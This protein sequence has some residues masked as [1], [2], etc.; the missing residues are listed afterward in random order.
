MNR[1]K[2]GALAIV[3][4]ATIVALV[5][6]FFRPVAVEVAY[7]VERAKLMLSRSVFSRVAG[8]FRG[9]QAKAENVRLRRE[10]ASL[11]MVMGECER[12]EEENARLRAALGYV[13]R[14]PGRWLA[15][16][17]LSE[18]GAAAGVGRSIRVDRG[19]LAGVKAGAVVA[20]PE[21]LVG[22]VV[23]VSPHTAEIRLITDSRLKVSCS[24]EG[25]QGAAGVLSGGTDSLLVLGLLTVGAEVPPRSRVFTSGRGGVFPAGIEVGTLLDVSEQPSGLGREGIVQPAVDFSTL[26]DV[27]IRNEK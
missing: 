3:A 2:N 15:A 19:S 12:L 26:E 18:N 20:V 6:A 7:P 22:R 1:K 17:V 21:G 13:E 5:F 4:L 14:E 27:F 24:V 9:A 10:V 11:A 23:S 8:L 25:S 16:S